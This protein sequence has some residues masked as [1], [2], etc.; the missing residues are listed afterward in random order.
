MNPSSISCRTASKIPQTEESFERWLSALSEK[1]MAFYLRP[2]VNKWL[3]TFKTPS[4]LMISDRALDL[5]F[6][7]KRLKAHTIHQTSCEEALQQFSEQPVLW[8]LIVFL[9]PNPAEEILTSV[10]QR[11]RKG[12]AFLWLT[13]NRSS[14]WSQWETFLESHDITQLFPV[15]FHPKGAVSWWPF[16]Q[17]V[18][19]TIGQVADILASFFP[20][21][22]EVALRCGRYWI[23]RGLKRDDITLLM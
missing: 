13:T 7:Q 9:H 19:N 8:D 16:E 12:G 6:W 15:G 10:L 17:G 11:L 21:R 2:L 22:Y 3:K 20:G 1:T 5:S 4:V 23:I 14:E 18:F